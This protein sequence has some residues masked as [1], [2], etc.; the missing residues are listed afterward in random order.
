M[1]AA[2]STPT[3]APR[4]LA[5]GKYTI[6]PAHSSIGFVA[7]HLGFARVRGTFS[8]VTGTIEVSPATGVASAE[9]VV[10]A[11]SVDT[12]NERRDEHLRS[13]EFLD[14][15]AHP[16][17]TFRTTSVEAVGDDQL[18]VGGDLTV[19]GV[20]RE[21]RLSVAVAGEGVDNQGR[22]V[23]GFQTAADIDRREFGITYSGTA[24][25][26]D[27]LVAERIRLEVD[28]LAARQS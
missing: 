19:R 3:H 18:E 8:D 13:A 15:D 1:R 21:L 14:A 27:A 5:A 28:V 7:R 20:S 2:I 9:V 24:P 23:I 17:I 11:A 22:D 10:A 26:G 25:G 12:G 6:D 4:A 16:A